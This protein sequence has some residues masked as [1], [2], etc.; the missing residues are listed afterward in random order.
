MLLPVPQLPVSARFD[1]GCEEESVLCLL[2]EA[3]EG[4]GLAQAV[5]GIYRAGK[6]YLVC[7]SEQIFW[8]RDGRAS[9]SLPAGALLVSREEELKQVESKFATM[10]GEIRRKLVLGLVFLTGGNSAP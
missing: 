7:V 8:L 10:L 1:E 2:S 9:T 6:D 3:A 5:P 4:I